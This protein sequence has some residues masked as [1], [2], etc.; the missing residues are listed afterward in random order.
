MFIFALGF[1]SFHCRGECWVRAT[2]WSKPVYKWAPGTLRDLSTNSKLSYEICLQSYTHLALFSWEAHPEVTW[3]S[4]TLIR[5]LKMWVIHSMSPPRLF[6]ELTGGLC[7]E[8][9]WCIYTLF[10]Y[11]GLECMF[12]LPIPSTN[13]VLLFLEILLTYW[14]FSSNFSSLSDKPDLQWQT[15]ATRE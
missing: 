11:Y 13:A 12:I 4:R 7:I 1:V 10:A 5:R 3:Q 6:K 15:A 9:S 2:P 14:W 8:N